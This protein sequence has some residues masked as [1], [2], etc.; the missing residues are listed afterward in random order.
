M[1]RHPRFR[2]PPLLALWL[3]LGLAL[4]GCTGGAPKAE[5]AVTNVTITLGD[6]FTLGLSEER[7][8]GA[9]VEAIGGATETVTWESSDTEVAAVGNTGLVTAVAKG[10]AT[11]T[12]TSTFDAEQSDSITVT[13]KA[14]DQTFRLTVT[15]S[16]G[17]VVGSDPNGIDCPNAC[18]ASFSLD[19]D[20]TLTAAPDA[21]SSFS[22]W[23]GACALETGLSCTLNESEAGA[24]E[25]TANFEPDEPGEVAV[26]LNSQSAALEPLQTTEFSATVTGSDDTNVTWATDGGA[27]EGAGNTV[28]Y[29]APAN[30]GSYTVTATSQA[31]PSKS[32]SASVTVNEVV[33]PNE[34]FTIVALPDTQNYV[35]SRCA[36][37]WHPDIFRAQT[38]WIVEN[39]D[40]LNIVFV[41]HEGD[42][43]EIGDGS[44]HRDPATGELDENREWLEADQ[45]I[46]T[47][48]G[49]M[50]YSVAIGDHDYNEEQRQ[51]SG[52]GGFRE[53]FGEDRYSGY[54]WYGGAGPRELSHYQLFSAGGY[55]FLHIALEWEAPDDALEWANSVI[56]E[57]PGLP[58]II[59]THG[60][61]NDHPDV[62]G[63]QPNPDDLDCKE[64]GTCRANSAEDI[65]Q[66]VVE[67]NP[68]VFMVLNGHYHGAPG[69]PTETSPS[70]DGE[71][72]Q[73]SNL[74][75]PYPVYEML[76]NYQDYDPEQSGFLR[77][78][79]FVP[80][81]G[82]NG[83]D[84]IG[85]ETYSPWLG[86]Y[87]TDRSSQFSFDLD[88][89]QRFSAP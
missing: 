48:D 65:F 70:N 5:P 9:D 23:G 26:S 32:A 27:L 33:D 42:V 73:I 75:T 63:R 13:V 1:I 74:D 45:A 55:E 10:T 37:K 83:Q 61:L 15:S 4:G 25:V 22:G 14:E 41:T 89:D 84:R 59:T 76:A 79:T 49:Q 66:I 17:G 62:R 56:A 80:E 57:N 51:S 40:A 30:P 82:E 39:Q 78:L 53:W 72:H 28:T 81:G 43:V 47:L 12:A 36:D 58:T 11:I 54:P 85:V 86:E 50:P 3:F 71:F 20:V 34:P 8:L 21:G 7:Q 19:E 18:E 64:G 6:D 67:P 68:Q 2:P 38:E 24:V 77:I 31:D 29:T 16:A 60:Y 52:A 35:C 46:E 87:Q 88:F 69:G 44:L